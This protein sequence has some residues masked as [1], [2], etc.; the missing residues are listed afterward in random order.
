[1][2][3]EKKAGFVSLLETKIKN[4]DMGKFYEL[5]FSNW[6][7]TS[8][9]A[10]LDRGRIVLA[11]NPHLFTVDIRKCSNQMLHCNVQQKQEKKWFTITIVYA[12]NEEEGRKELWKQLRDIAGTIQ[13]LWL[14]V[15]DS[16]IYK[17]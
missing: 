8:N 12:F 7:F 6:C 3:M 5:L 4:K 17:S 1:M 14:V 11:W 15:G 16:C 2:I 10:W 13:L 9:N